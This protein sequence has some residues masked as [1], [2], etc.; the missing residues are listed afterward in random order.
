MEYRSHCFSLIKLVF[1]VA[2]TTNLSAI[3]NDLSRSWNRTKVFPCSYVFVKEKAIQESSYFSIL[4]HNSTAFL[5]DYA[6]ATTMPPVLRLDWRIGDRS[7]RRARQNSSFVCQANTDC[8][9]FDANIGGYLCTCS[10]GYQGNPYL[11]SGC[12]G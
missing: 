6:A 5:R 11:Y 9:D 1:G 12:M 2:G 10:K 7:C 4:E 8:I 3:L